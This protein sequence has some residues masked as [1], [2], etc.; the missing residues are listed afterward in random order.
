[1]AEIEDDELFSIDKV[2]VLNEN[3]V[4]RQDLV[5]KRVILE[6]LPDGAVIRRW[7]RSI[8]LP[9]KAIARMMGYSRAH[10]FKIECGKYPVN[11]NFL[12]NLR[13][14]VKRIE[15]GLPDVPVTVMHFPRPPR[16]K[17]GKYV[18]VSAVAGTAK[19]WRRCEKCGKVRLFTRKTARYCSTACSKAAYRERKRD[20][21]LGKAAGVRKY[22]DCPKCGHTFPVRNRAYSKATYQGD[23]Q[24]ENDETRRLGAEA[25]GAEVLAAMR[26]DTGAAGDNAVRQVSGSGENNGDGVLSDAGEGAVGDSV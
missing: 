13:E 19:E 14:V 25:E 21:T 23:G 6:D 20:G 22:V 4:K 15:K 10:I 17:E 18:N 7:R 9:M 8:N 16:N 11:G 12:T 26:S 5:A 24:A 3:I 2:K 1:M